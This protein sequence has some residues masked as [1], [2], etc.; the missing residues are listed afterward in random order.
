[1][2]FVA[3]IIV[4]FAF[5]FAVSAQ[6]KKPSSPSKSFQIKNAKD[7]DAMT[8]ELERQPGNVSRDIVPAKG[9]QT[10]IAVFFDE[11]RENDMFEVHDAAD[12]IYY[13]LGGTATLVLGGE[14]V[15]ASEISPGEWRAKTVSGGNKFEIKKGD[16]IF[17][18][19]GTVHQ[20]TVTGKG[21]SMILVKVFATEQR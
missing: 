21:F 9:M 4:I 16:L 7:I 19:R 15:E 5:C 14:L 18:P 1:M 6:T 3:P 12:D 10:R 13:V 20:R 8:K 17:V 2:K 11:K